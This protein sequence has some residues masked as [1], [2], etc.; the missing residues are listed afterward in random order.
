LSNVRF[1]SKNLMHFWVLGQKLAWI[2]K[3]NCLLGRR[4]G[5]VW[6]FWKL[7]GQS[8]GRE[9]RKMRT[10]NHIYNCAK[11]QLVTDNGFKNHPRLVYA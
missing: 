1:L 7:P 11:N 5:R 8:W 3:K 4:W 10:A 6:I 9:F 2:F